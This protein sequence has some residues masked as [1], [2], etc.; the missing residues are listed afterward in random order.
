MCSDAYRLAEEGAAR[1][2]IA[3]YDDVVARFDSSRDEY[4]QDMVAYALAQRA[5][6]R[7]T[8]SEIASRGARPA[9]LLARFECARKPEQR[10]DLARA[11]VSETAILALNDRLEEAVALSK[12]LLAAVEDSDS[13]E[14]RRIAAVGLQNEVELLI[15]G[16]RAA[17]AA[18]ALAH[19]TTRFGEELLTW[20]D[21]DIPQNS[22]A[23]RD[24]RLG[25]LYRRAEVLRAM[26]RRDEALD[27]YT[28]VISEFGDDPEVQLV[29]DRARERRAEL[30]TE[31]D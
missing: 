13:P 21:E 10:K 25:L 15:G 4:L 7:A 22:D 19:L 28:E 27:A 6:L 3:I 18:E 17:E 8:H 9:D 24:T 1:E 23:V 14:V 16:G 31:Q 2:A 20:Y 11:I 5:E 29:I 30:T 12:N 26:G